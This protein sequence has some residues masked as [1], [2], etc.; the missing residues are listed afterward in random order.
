MAPVAV[1]AEITIHP[2]E[3]ALGAEVRGINLNEPLARDQV[4]DLRS[5]WAEHLVLRFRGQTEL[6]LE[7]QIAFSG[8]FGK[9]DSRP[10]VSYEMSQQHNELPPEITVI[11]NVKIDNK[12]LGALGDGEAVWHSDM[13]YNE[14]PPRGACLYAKEIPLEG[15]NT[16]FANLQEAY[17]TL[18]ADTKERIATLN[19][20]HDAS[21]NSAGEL[22]LGFKDNIDPRNTVGAVHPLVVKH[23]VSGR[24]QL[25]LGRR[26]RAYIPGLPLEDSEALLDRLWAHATQ[27]RFMWT[28]CWQVGDLVMWD[29]SATLHRRDA[30]DP[31][32]RRLMYRTQIAPV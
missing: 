9:L 6:T 15:G 22:R 18:D 2:F 17:S 25:L 8:H 31:Q 16:S 11:S 13:T 7:S 14:H 3:G 29:N 24:P 10:T 20:V 27:P 30:F 21:H 28:Q 19:C 26:P 1:A 23:V 5:A 32:S 12:P 4:N